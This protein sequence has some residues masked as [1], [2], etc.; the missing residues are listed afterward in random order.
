MLDNNFRRTMYRLTYFLI[1]LKL[2]E[3]A[4]FVGNTELN[5]FLLGQFPNICSKLLSTVAG[6]F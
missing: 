6:H 4:P 3:Y 5:H 1:K 2:S